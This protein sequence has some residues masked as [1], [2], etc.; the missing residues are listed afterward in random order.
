MRLKVL[1]KLIRKNSLVNLQHN[2]GLIIVKYEMHS[3]F[4]FDEKQANKF[5]KE[6]ER[7]REILLHERDMVIFLIWYFYAVTRA[8]KNST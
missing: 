2:K 4:F 1:G 5:K 7:K 8:E 3:E 6:K